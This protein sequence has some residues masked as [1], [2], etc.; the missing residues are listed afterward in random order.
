[1]SVLATN[2]EYIRGGF[3]PLKHKSIVMGSKEG[4]QMTSKEGK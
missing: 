1:L 4:K 2:D 3:D